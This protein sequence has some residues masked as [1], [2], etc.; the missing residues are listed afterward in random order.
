M[1]KYQGAHRLRLRKTQCRRFRQ[2]IAFQPAEYDALRRTAFFAVRNVEFGKQRPKRLP[3]RELA[4]VQQSSLIGP[5]SFSISGMLVSEGRIGRRTEGERFNPIGIEMHGKFQ[6]AAGEI[7]CSGRKQRKVHLVLRYLVFAVV[8]HRD[9]NR[10]GERDLHA[11]VAKRQ[12]EFPHLFPLGHTISGTGFR[13]Y[14]RFSPVKQDLF[15]RHLR[16]R[17]FE[18]KYQHPS[19]NRALRL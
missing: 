17:Q 7:P 1:K 11:A 8:I 18:L 12:R 9:V 13:K 15:S 6:F 16:L 10:T 19:R 2:V 5:S 3:L 14:Y 4:E